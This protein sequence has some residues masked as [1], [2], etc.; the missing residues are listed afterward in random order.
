MTETE[1]T[2]PSP[3]TLEHTHARLEPLSLQHAGEL[4]EAGR[5][6]EI[7]RYL[8]APP[9]GDV[10]AMTALIEPALEELACL[11]GRIRPISR[12]RLKNR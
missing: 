5:D 8:P 2:S 7:W 3:I 6:A 4:F 12:T 9:P 11:R 10:A 1:W